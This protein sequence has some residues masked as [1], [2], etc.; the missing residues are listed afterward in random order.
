MNNIVPP[1]GCVKTTNA[2]EAGF[3]NYS[4]LINPVKNIEECIDKAKSNSNLCNNKDGSKKCKYFVYNDKDHYDYARTAYKEY[5]KYK[6]SLREK[7]KEKYLNNSIQL[8]KNLWLSFSPS[9][10][11]EMHNGNRPFLLNYCPNEILNNP[12]FVKYI[13]DNL[14]TEMFNL[15]V[16]NMCWIGGDIVLD[17]KNTYLGDPTKNNNILSDCGYNMYIIPGTH[18]TSI[19]D[20]TK[21]MFEQ[22]AVDADR[23]IKKY[24]N[25]KEKANAL[26]KYVENSSNENIFSLMNGMNNVKKRIEIDIVT[27]DSF[28]NLSENMKK[29]KLLKEKQK[30]LKKSKD[31]KEKLIEMQLISDENAANEQSNIEHENRKLEWSLRYS[32]DRETVRDNI[33]YVLSIVLILLSILLIGMI[34]YFILLKNRISNSNKS[35]DVKGYKNA[36]NSLFTKNKKKGLLF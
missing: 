25:E 5:L 20:K 3:I 16:E 22:K 13:E 31:I 28:R 10:R 1:I 12:D 19:I 2:R 34:L 23:M 33:I 29:N 35:S 9:E 7:E 15:P 11:K 17:N 8:F 36:L 18:G 32:W 14:N 4:E 24:T 21:K 27:K 30:I 26:A 6:E